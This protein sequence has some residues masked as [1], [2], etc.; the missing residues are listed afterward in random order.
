MGL[1]EKKVVR[2]PS[3][4]RLGKKIGIRMIPKQPYTGLGR[5]N[6]LRDPIQ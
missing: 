6:D 4:S 5:K 2:D 1:W 3:G